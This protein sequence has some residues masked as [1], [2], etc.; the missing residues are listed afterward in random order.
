MNI[1]YAT[2]TF[3]SFGPEENGWSYS[4]PFDY[5]TLSW[6]E[7]LGPKPNQLDLALA[8]VEHYYN[9][10]VFQYKNERSSKYPSVEDQLDQIFHGS[11]TEWKKT[12]KAIKDAHPKT[13]VNSEELERRKQEVR[14]FLS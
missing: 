4:D 1:D 5:S 12:I 3:N 8:S 9:Q 2:P 13:T 6:D 7:K 14:D 10:E 11:V